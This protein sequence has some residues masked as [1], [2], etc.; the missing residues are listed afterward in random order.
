MALLPFFACHCRRTGDHPA[1][2]TGRL[3]LRHAVAKTGGRRSTSRRELVGSRL[4]RVN[5]LDCQGNAL[6]PHV[7]CEYSANLEKK[8]EIDALLE[9]LHSAMMRTGAAEQ[10]V[11]LDL[12]LQVGGI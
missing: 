6:M 4:P 10:G 7:I 9:A 2:R 11:D 3:S 5:N 12:L 8:I 1:L